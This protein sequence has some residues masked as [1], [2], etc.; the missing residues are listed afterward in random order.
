MDTKFILLW[1]E[2]PIQSWGF[3]SKFGRRDTLNFPTKSGVL[4]LVCCAMGATGEQVELLKQFSELKQTVISYVRAKKDKDGNTIKNPHEPL[5]HDFQMIGNGYDNKDPWQSLL[6]PKK[7]D[8][9]SAV[10]GGT[11]LTHRYYLQDA[12][13]AVI[14]EVPNHLAEVISEALQNPVYDIYLGR[15]CCVPS[16]FIYQGLYTS[17]DD[18]KIA[19]NKKAESK[20]HDNVFLIENFTVV[21]GEFNEGD[22]FTLNDVPIQFGKI[23]KYKDRRVTVIS[24]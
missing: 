24:L 13:F 19:A 17:V 9:K 10:G 12:V 15:K 11:K 21:D 7:A 14:L 5:L 23:K 8:G 20:Q 2:A 16:D 3:D 6:I 18:A 1:L 4:G 22:S